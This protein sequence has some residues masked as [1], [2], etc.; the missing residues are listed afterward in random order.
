MRYLGEGD[1]DKNQIVEEISKDNLITFGSK[2]DDEYYQFLIRDALE[3][4][5][6]RMH[7]RSFFAKKSSDPIYN[8][9]GDKA[10]DFYKTFDDLRKGK[11]NVVAAGDR[12]KHPFIVYIDESNYVAGV[13]AK[14]SLYIGYGLLE[15]WAADP[16]MYPVDGQG[17]KAFYILFQAAIAYLLTLFIGFDRTY[18]RRVQKVFDN[19]DILSKNLLE[20][21][22][23]T[24]K[25]TW[26]GS[27][28][29]QRR[30]MIA[31][32]G[33]LNAW[34]EFMEDSSWLEIHHTLRDTKIVEKEQSFLDTAT[35]EISET[36][37]G[38]VLDDA[39]KSIFSAEAMEERERQRREKQMDWT[40][41]RIALGILYPREKA[42]LKQLWNKKKRIMSWRE[43]EETYY[44]EIWDLMRR[45]LAGE[46]V[47]KIMDEKEQKSLG[48]WHF[49]FETRKSERPREKVLTL[50]K[51]S[52][53]QLM[54]RKNRLLEMLQWEGE[55]LPPDA[56]WKD[57]VARFRKIMIRY[58]PDRVEVTKIDPEEAREVT[59][60]AISIFR[61]LEIIHDLEP[62]IF[63][64]ATLP[65]DYIEERK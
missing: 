47:E 21:V 2:S 50:E 62:G 31:L 9:L 17:Y 56:P 59:S 58:H 61:E 4:M 49:V 42:Y 48:K 53:E 24:K 10:K 15:A 64:L 6:K 26:P 20:C 51:M 39:V 52:I 13:A 23:L 63:G 46:D 5:N 30:A 45:H 35:T 22:T 36:A 44:E 7:W 55:G 38:I 32:R 29:I 27:P 54:E 65:E 16:R 18:A 43:L 1:I 37:R 41:L 28:Q 40:L 57:V 34:F 33:Y 11:I 25:G 8:I 60:R 3:V 19:D 14:R 12:Y